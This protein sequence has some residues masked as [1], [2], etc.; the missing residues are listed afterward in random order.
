MR[1]YEL[2]ETLLDHAIRALKEYTIISASRSPT[3][4]TMTRC[5]PNFV[6]DIEKARVE[7]LSLM[8]MELENSRPLP[9]PYESHLS[10]LIC[11]IDTCRVHTIG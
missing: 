3:D 1:V 4:S 9:Y 5:N 11:Y 2:N 6:Q 7:W 10:P 8:V